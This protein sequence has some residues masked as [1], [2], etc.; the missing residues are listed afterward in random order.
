MKFK[1]SK[2]KISKQKPTAIK[3]KS[4]ATLGKHLHHILKSNFYKL[5]NKQ[6]GKE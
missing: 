6:K 3:K 4:K 1:T 2:N 5:I